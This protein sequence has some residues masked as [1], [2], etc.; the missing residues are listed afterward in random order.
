[1]QK[2]QGQGSNPYHSCDPSHSSDHWILNPL[3]HQGIAFKNIDNQT[4]KEAFS[5]QKVETSGQIEVI[6]L[7]PHIYW[8]STEDPEV[9]LLTDPAFI[10]AK[11]SSR[12]YVA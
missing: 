7:K 10:S 11:Q 5:S 1:M 12:A 3:S 2:F 6:L 8:I 4:W 9:G